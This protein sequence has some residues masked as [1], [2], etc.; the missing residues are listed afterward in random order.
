MRKQTLQGRA[1]FVLWSVALQISQS[2]MSYAACRPRVPQAAGKVLAAFKAAAPTQAQALTQAQSSSRTPGAE[3]DDDVSDSTVVPR[4]AE[5]LRVYHS[6][7]VMLY[8]SRAPLGPISA[9]NALAPHSPLSW[10]KQC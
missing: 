2:L 5:P 10:R 9:P 8:S 7:P 4:L 1:A 3:R 6:N